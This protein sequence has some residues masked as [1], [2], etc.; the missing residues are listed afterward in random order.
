ME[1]ANDPLVAPK[2]SPFKKKKSTL[3]NTPKGG[4]LF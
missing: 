2:K 3:N 1:S 4:F